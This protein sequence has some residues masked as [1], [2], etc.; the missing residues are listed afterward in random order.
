MPALRPSCTDLER[1]SPSLLTIMQG[2]RACREK[3]GLTS[4]YLRQ[5]PGHS[6]S[7]DATRSTTKCPTDDWNWESPSIGN[8]DGCAGSPALLHCLWK[9]WQLFARHCETVPLVYS[10]RERRSLNTHIFIGVLTPRLAE[11]M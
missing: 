6:W 10:K 9:C 11:P 7:L 5:D 2:M 3:R 8:V 4:W 1:A